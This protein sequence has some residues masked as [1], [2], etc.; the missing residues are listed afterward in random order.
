MDLC[1]PDVRDAVV[2]LGFEWDRG[3]YDAEWG[4]W[5]MATRS[6]KHKIEVYGSIFK[7]Y[8]LKG[9]CYGVPYYIGDERGM[10]KIA[11]ILGN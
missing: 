3:R 8:Q 9:M 5:T 1:F 7:I 2:K 4:V 11:E 6:K 10:R